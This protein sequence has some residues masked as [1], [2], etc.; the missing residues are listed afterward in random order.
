MAT[1]QNREM[2]A[3][4]IVLFKQI[5]QYDTCRFNWCLLEICTNFRKNTLQYI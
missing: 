1:K 2:K 4:V 5:L 3:L